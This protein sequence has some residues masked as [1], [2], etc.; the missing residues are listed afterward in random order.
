MKRSLTQ[1]HLRGQLVEEL[2]AEVEPLAEAD[3]DAHEG[4]PG[5]AQEGDLLG[6]GEHEAEHL[7]GDDRHEDDQDHGHQQDDAE[8][9]DDLVDRQEKTFARRLSFRAREP[10][11]YDDE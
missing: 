6:P 1:E 8:A 11:L 3:R 10:S 2:H 9:V 4:E 7:A 5:E